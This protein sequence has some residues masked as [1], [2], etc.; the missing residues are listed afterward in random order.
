MSWDEI[1]R[2]MNEDAELDDAGV[3]RASAKLRK[4]F[5]RAKN[6]LGEL[7]RERGIGGR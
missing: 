1:A 2:V 4:R 7:A 6:T 5:E 3:K